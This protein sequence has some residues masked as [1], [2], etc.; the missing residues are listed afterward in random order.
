MLNDWFV[1]VHVDFDV[2]SVGHGGAGFAWPHCS[3]LGAQ[4]LHMPMLPTSLNTSDTEEES[5]HDRDH[6]YAEP[7]DH[8]VNRLMLVYY[9]L[10]PCTLAMITLGSGSLHSCMPSMYII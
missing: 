10:T 8:E 2:E 1:A 6:D 7:V 4:P 9:T 5:V 3:A